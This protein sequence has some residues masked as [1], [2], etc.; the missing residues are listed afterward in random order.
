MLQRG[1]GLKDEGVGGGKGKSQQGPQDQK[2]SRVLSKEPHPADQG[3]LGVSGSNPSTGN[4]KVVTRAMGLDGAQF[5]WPKGHSDNRCYENKPANNNTKPK[6]LSIY[7]IKKFL[8]INFL[9]ILKLKL[10]PPPPQKIKTHTTLEE[11]QKYSL[12]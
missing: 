4:K 2:D 7:F 1:G 9:K 6:T 8:C 3:V 10:N 11:C 12:L 5:P